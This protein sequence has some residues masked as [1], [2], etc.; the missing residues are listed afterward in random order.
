MTESTQKEQP[1]T[2]QWSGDVLNRDS[3]AR[4][5]TDTLVGQSKALASTDKG[6]TVSLDAGWGAGKTFFIRHWA[7]DL[8]HAGHPVVVFD[9]WEHDIGDDA[10]IALMSAIHGEF[11]QSL[12]RSSQASRLI[13][14]SLTNAVH[15]LRKAILPTSKIIAAGLFRKVSGIAIDELWEAATGNESGDNSGDG[16]LETSLDKVFE[17]TLESHRRRREEIERFKKSISG[18]IESLVENQQKSLPAF[19]MVDEVDRCR[20]TYAIRLLEEIKHIFGV[21]DICFVVSTNISQL[22][23]SVCGVYG[24]GFDGQAYLNRFFDQTFVLPN[25]DNASYAT[26]LLAQDDI[27]ASRK[28]SAGMPYAPKDMSGIE[29]SVALIF[30]AFDSDLRSQKQVLSIARTAASAIPQENKIFVLWLFFLCALRQKK[31]ILFDR[32]RGSKIDT[33]EFSEICKSALAND[34]LIAY[35]VRDETPARRLGSSRNANLSTVLSNY[36]AWSRKDLKELREVSI[37]IYEYP[38]SNLRE[39][40]EEMPPQYY[41]GTLYPPSISTYYDL[42]RYAGLLSKT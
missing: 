8:R 10:A 30:N 6:L 11:L 28:C 9:A 32:L 34:V 33:S 18:V 39:I 7:D 42:V 41:P 37:N 15:G 26:H 24:G 27:F 23:E 4:F 1:S 17:K 40:S 29:K 3:L 19:V 5:L 36:Y 35:E 31:P 12:D 22:K 21:K 14:E 25:A 38:A 2:S 13:E 16:S 20:P